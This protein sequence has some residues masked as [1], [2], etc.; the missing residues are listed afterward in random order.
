MK[1]MYRLIACLL[2]IVMLLGAIPTGF[3]ANGDMNERSPSNPPTNGSSDIPF[4]DVPK[5]SWFYDAVV[6]VYQLGLFGGTT[7]STF[8]PN[9]PM[10]RGMFV[11]VLYRLHSGGGYGYG[12][13]CEEMNPGVR[14]P[15]TSFSDVPA[16]AWYAKGVKWAAERGIVS[17]VGNN[18]FN[19]DGIVTREQAAVILW[20]FVN[21][22]FMT[23]SWKPKSDETKAN[24]SFRDL[25]QI[26]SWAMQGVAQCVNLGI[27][28]GSIAEDGYLYFYPQKSTTRAE[29]ATMFLRVYYN[30]YINS[31]IGRYV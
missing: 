1:R 29:A 20:N 22:I 13:T 10:T 30:S 12:P 8:S 15:V 28:T 6:M 4:Y 18:K 17:G 3:A 27:I 23:R 24:G 9:D 26:S 14:P 19:P 21:Y 7:S 2:A 5:N 31:V 11:T 16:R 25:N